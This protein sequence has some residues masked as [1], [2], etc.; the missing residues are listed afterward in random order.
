MMK[1][2]FIKISLFIVVII[3]NLTISGQTKLENLGK[4][5]NSIYS[6][7]RPTISPD[8]KILYFVV[9]GSPLNN[10]YKSDKSIQDV[11]VSIQDSSGAW[12]KAERCPSPINS[13]SDNAVFW[14]SL[15]GKSILIRGAFENGKYLGRGFSLCNKNGVTWSDPQRL[16]I[17]GYNNMSVDEFDGAYLSTDG[18][19]LLLYMSEEKNSL[20]NDIY[21]SFFEKDNEWSTPHKIMDDV[22]TV[23]YDEISPFLSS[24]DITMY[25]SSNR[26]GGFGSYDIWMT[27]RTDETWENWSKPVNLGSSINTSKWDAY[28]STDAK[29]EYGYISSNTKSIG[30]TDIERIKLTDAQKPNPIVFVYGKIKTEN[31]ND[32]IVGLQVAFNEINDKLDTIA[33]SQNKVIQSVID[34]SD[35][36]YRGILPYGKK[37]GL[38]IT[39]DNYKTQIDTL[40][41]VNQGSYQELH[42]QTS[43][44]IE[45]PIIESKIDTINIAKKGKRK[46][47]K[48]KNID[49]LKESNKANLELGEIYLIDDILFDFDKSTLSKSSFEQ[50]NKAVAL[51]KN[52]PSVKIELSAHTDN[53]G[54]IIYNDSLSNKRAK[55]AADYIISKGGSPKRISSKGYGGSMPIESNDT[56]EGRSLNR[57]VEIKIIQK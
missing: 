51:M 15:D 20:L 13:K 32:S 5:V 46:I 41:L 50:L 55:A 45:N 40:D 6:E 1:I 8:G 54:T 22:S 48:K 34:P 23:D 21:V 18:K 10:N 36:S 56:P 53:I 16:K 57:R 44:K 49:D 43:L 37:Y 39:A 52:N 33:E 19:K 28:F 25:F 11:W 4:N 2:N 17:K 24:D 3:S 38:K 31:P 27:K 29:G 26:P 9:Q 42:N 12:A 35:N 14:T 7:L 47:E 30:G